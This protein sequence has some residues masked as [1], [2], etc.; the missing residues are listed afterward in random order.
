MTP[1]ASI[2]VAIVEDNDKLRE[3]FAVLFDGASGFKCVGAHRTAEEACKEIPL[4]KPDV[5]LMDIRLPGMSGIRCM[6]HIKGILPSVKVVM[7]TVNEDAD[8]LFQSLRAGASGYL[9]K[10]T[11]ATKVLEALSEAYQGSAPMSGRIARMVVEHF[12]PKN[13]AD[14]TVTLTDREREILNHLAKGT[15]NKEIADALK[16]NLETVRTHLRNIYEKLHVNSRTEAVL[17]YLEK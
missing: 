15:R 6:Q 4:H 9:L 17:K 14:E 12:Y 13:S 1:A 7:H 5:V 3:S 2:K 10:G 11:P 16:I 8:L